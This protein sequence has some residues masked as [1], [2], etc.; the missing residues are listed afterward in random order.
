MRTE[1]SESK[2]NHQSS[3]RATRVYLRIAGSGYALLMRIQRLKPDEVM[4]FFYGLTGRSAVL[5]Y[6]FPEREL[7]TE[8]LKNATIDFAE[9]RR[10]DKPVDH[11]TSHADG[12]FHIRTFDKQDR[13]VHRA[14]RAAPLGRATGTFLQCIVETDLANEYALIDGQPKSPFAVIDVEPGESI[15]M[16][17][18]FSGADYP[19][20]DTAHLSLPDIYGDAPVPQPLVSVQ[21]GNLRGAFWRLPGRSSNANVLRQPGTIV[22]LKFRLANGKHHIKTFV[23]D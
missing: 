5:R 23:F 22:S 7:A 19:L 8:E 15:A 11:F 2:L 18:W 14:Q 4:L 20:E 3:T 13:Y 12:E 1:V 17:G 9:A 21:A 16:R 6:Q 10:V